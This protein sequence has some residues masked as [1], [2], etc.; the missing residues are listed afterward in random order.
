MI[1]SDIQNLIYIFKIHGEFK[2]KRDPSI[3][4]Y[5]CVCVCGGW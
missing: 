1:E 4:V 2:I 5:V 3:G